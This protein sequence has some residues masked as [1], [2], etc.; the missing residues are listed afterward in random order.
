MDLVEALKDSARSVGGGQHR[1]RRALVAFEFALALALLTGGGLALH[2][3]F[4]MTRV[5]LGL[6]HGAAAHVR[7]ARARGRLGPAER[8]NAF[9]RELLDRVRARPGVLSA[10]VFGRRA[11]RGGYGRRS[12]PGSGAG[13]ARTALGRAERRQSRATIETLG[14]RSCAGATSPT[15]TA[16]APAGRAW[17]TRRSRR[18]SPASIRSTSGSSS[19]ARPETPAGEPRPSGRSSA[20]RRRAERRPRETLP[21]IQLPFWQFPWPARAWPSAPR[22]IPAASSKT[23]AGVLHAMDPDLPW[24]T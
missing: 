20:L 24:G 17:S 23:L 2:S 8:M 13:D 14:I 12:R 3:F 10:S 6:A 7:R 9:Y 18:T 21:E 11:L 15:R 22:A 4:R 5:D 1:L 16:S 19:S